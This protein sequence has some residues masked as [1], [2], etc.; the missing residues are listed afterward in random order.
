MKVAHSSYVTEETIWHK[1]PQANKT[2]MTRQCG[3]ICSF[4]SSWQSAKKGKGK[5]ATQLQASKTVSNI[6]KQKALSKQA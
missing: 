4:V 6:N 5:A 1:H 2:I 3:L